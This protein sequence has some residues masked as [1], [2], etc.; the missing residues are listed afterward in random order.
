MRK[1]REERISN[2]EL[3]VNLLIPDD[4]FFI[5]CQIRQTEDRCTTENYV[6]GLWN[7]VCERT[8]SNRVTLITRGRKCL[9]Y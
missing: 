1:L 3:V 9:C 6:L 7:P 8:I 5:R 2:Y 4:S